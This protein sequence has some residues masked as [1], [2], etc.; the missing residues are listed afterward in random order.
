MERTKA[1][2]C[3]DRTCQPF[4]PVV[5]D[6]KV[7]GRGSGED[8][9]GTACIATVLRIIT[10]D[11]IDL[12]RRV[13]FASTIYEGNSLTSGLLHL[14]GLAPEAAPYPNGVNLGLDIGNLGG[15]SFPA[16]RA[17]HVRAEAD[18]S[19]PT[20]WPALGAN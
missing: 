2:N 13:I 4:T 19:T 15:H 17:H 20:R 5:R 18:I 11:R 10:D 16:P 9:C 3:S 1:F 7:Y 8:N 14:M 12:K 6:G